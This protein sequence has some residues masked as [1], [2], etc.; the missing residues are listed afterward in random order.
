MAIVQDDCCTKWLLYKMVIVQ[1]GDCTKWRL[2]KIAI[3]QYGDQKAIVSVEERIFMLACQIVKRIQ[4]NRY[5]LLFYSSIL[6]F[7]AYRSK[8][9]FL[10]VRSPTSLISIT[11]VITF[12]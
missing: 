6:K 2:Y 12:Q 4:I 1:S 7:E 9:R 11:I 3:I 10:K 5:F 8:F